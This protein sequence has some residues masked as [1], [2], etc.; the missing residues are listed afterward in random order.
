MSSDRMKPVKVVAISVALRQGMNQLKRHNFL[1]GIIP[2]L[3]FHFISPLFYF[4][5]Q[6]Q[7]IFLMC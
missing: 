1:K 7:S 5:L 2:F 4:C 3:T 6:F